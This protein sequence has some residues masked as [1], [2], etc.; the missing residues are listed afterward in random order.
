[1]MIY[2]TSLIL[3]LTSNLHCLGMC[4][5]LVLA[6][7]MKRTSRLGTLFQLLQYHFGRILVYAVL[8]AVFGLLGFTIN[9]FGIMQW[10]SILFGVLMLLF[11][12][13]KWLLV[14]LEKSL[15]ILGFSKLFNGFY[16][17][18]FATRSPLKMFL[19]GALNGI[20]PCG[21]VYLG[22]LNALLAGSALGSATAMFFFGIGTMPALLVVGFA[23]GSITP[24][25]RSKIQ[26]FVPY[27]MSVVALMLIVRGMNLGIPYL[28]PKVSL[29]QTEVKKQQ[30]QEVKMS[31][32]HAGKAC[33]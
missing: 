3:G 33:E 9:S 25:V 16:A 23:A 4:G 32:C 31:C 26:L 20:L 6:V 10:V 1:M 2:L 21:M 19:L 11:A 14:S 18:L 29:Q 27:L 7:P 12:W 15:G 28:S 30:K 13:R 5:P 22:V 8:G 24:K 17:K